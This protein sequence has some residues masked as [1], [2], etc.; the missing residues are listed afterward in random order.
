MAARRLWFPPGIQ[1]EKAARSK[2]RKRSPQRCM[3]EAGDLAGKGSG[4][5]GGGAKGCA[6]CSRNCLTEAGVCE[7]EDDEDT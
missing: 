1:P 7:E 5:G 4:G 6:R 2:T 3:A